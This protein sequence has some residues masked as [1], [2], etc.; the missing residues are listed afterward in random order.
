MADREMTH[1]SRVEKLK[2]MIVK[3]MNKHFCHVQEQNLIYYIVRNQFGVKTFASLKKTDFMDSYCHLSVALNKIKRVKASADA[4]P[5]D[6]KVEKESGAEMLTFPKVWWHHRGKRT[7]VRS[8]F[9]PNLPLYAP[10][11]HINEY[12]GFRE[13]FDLKSID[14]VNPHDSDIALARMF[15]EHIHF[16]VCGGDTQKFNWLTKWMAKRILMPWVKLNSVPVFSGP[17]GVGKTVGVDV[18]SHLFG[19]MVMVTARL[20]QLMKA[21]FNSETKNK[22]LLIFEE[23]FFSGDSEVDSA[24]KHFLTGTSHEVRQKFREP[25]VAPNFISC[26]MTTN[27]NNTD[28][29]LRVS[30]VGR[31]WAIFPVMDI[32]KNVLLDAHK[33][34]F[35]TLTKILENPVAHKA[36]YKWLLNK[37][38]DA[39]LVAFGN[40][41]DKPAVFDE[42]LARQR[43]MG[44]DT[45]AAFWKQA[46]EAGHHVHPSDDLC[47]DFN[48]LNDETFALRGGEGR[49]EG[50]DYDY[51]QKEGRVWKVDHAWTSVTTEEQ[52]YDWYSIQHK[53]KRLNNGPRMKKNQNTVSKDTFLGVSRQLGILGRSRGNMLVKHTEVA[54]IRSKDIT[55]GLTMG[56]GTVKNASM[57]FTLVEVY[58]YND[59]Y[60]KFLT[61][62]GLVES[63]VPP[64]KELKPYV[65]R[66][67]PTGNPNADAIY[68]KFS[69]RLEETRKRNMGPAKVIEILDDDDD[70]VEEP[71]KKRARIEP[72]IK[73]ESEDLAPQSEAS[74]SEDSQM[75]KLEMAKRLLEQEYLEK[76]E[77]LEADMAAAKA[78]VTIANIKRDPY[79]AMRPCDGFILGGSPSEP[80]DL[81]DEETVERKP[82]IPCTPGQELEA[83]LSPWDLSQDLFG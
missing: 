12:P 53:L 42:E 32:S 25:K 23:G 81:D 67:I 33:S 22:L 31:R 21:S 50:V 72:F 4:K 47:S 58:P 83:P 71:P 28:W 77:Q 70:E 82:L 66:F 73:G 3:I 24:L 79:A 15:M 35:S 16:F 13:G 44:L 6:P 10:F 38:S 11:I 56:L 63:Q 75:E 36:W 62:T 43:A 59:S 60:H 17:E 78:A 30:S 48:C 40:G 49:R 9:S 64:V 5:D 52:L 26:M 80:I 68:A 55:W 14:E 1:A 37:H 61:K 2:T 19:D 69:T 29:Y 27:H 20:N 54:S 45:V 8:I 46:L 57:R 65:P 18:F 34:Y 41:E 39:E 74:Q 7:V 76:L 51:V